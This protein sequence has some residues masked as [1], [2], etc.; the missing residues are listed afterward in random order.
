MNSKQKNQ[1]LDLIR[2]PVTK[3]ALTEADAAEISEINSAI[4]ARQVFNR[5][6]QAESQKIDGG[7]FNEDRS[8]LLPVRDGIIILVSD[9]ALVVNSTD[10]SDS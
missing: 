10:K 5:L 2:C 4:D 9:Q 8:L 3:S 1:V 6:G 7:Y